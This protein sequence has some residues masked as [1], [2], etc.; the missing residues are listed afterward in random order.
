METSG[1]AA[2][3]LR[4][5]APLRPVVAIVGRPNVGKSTLFNRLLGRRQAI[6]ND[7]PGV[8][9]DLIY[10]E[11]EWCNHRFTLVDTGGF[12]PNTRDALVE[13]IKSQAELAIAEADVA[14]LLCD[15]STGVVD[16]DRE[17]ARILWRSS[18][19]SM[20]AV[21]KMD[22]PDQNAMLEEF[23]SLGLGEPRPVS[24]VTG[25]YTGDLLDALV[26]R[27]AEGAPVDEEQ[28]SAIKVV[29][30][31]RPNVGKSTLINRLAGQQISI[32]H[33][34]PG[35]TR[36]TTSIR[37]A[38]EGHEFVFMDTAGLRRRARV[39]DQ[40]EYFSSL[41][42]SSSIQQADVAVVL[43]DAVEGCTGQDV[44][45]MSQVIDAGCG[46]VPAVNKWDLSSVGTSEFRRD[47]HR[48]F[49][50]LTDYPLLFISA[51]TGKRVMGC[52]RTIFKVYENC[53][54]RVPT[55][56]LNRLVEQ[57]EQRAPPASQGREVK[58]LYA[59]Q[60]AV[61]PPTFV[62]FS[63]RPELVSDS[64]KRFIEKSLRAEFGFSGTPVRTVWRKRRNS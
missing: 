4:Q 13:A 24:A 35:T 46:L 44:R 47:M 57:L 7:Q 22:H 50:F 30:A 28:D 58:L 37:L 48:R 26:Q 42:A 6:I 43:L 34:K 21:N 5:V 45:I 41:R 19:P 27:F 40:I 51:L 53:C 61:A 31:G 15:A 36:D 25:R 10:G 20:V 33:E 52:L 59:T 23:Y 39:D 64:Y 49:P 17:V 16:L 8:T 29:M 3:E 11:T 62:I 2:G 55:A 32:V 14:I 18:H 63:N 12:V 9:R 60:H 38:W 54:S 1:T 56:R